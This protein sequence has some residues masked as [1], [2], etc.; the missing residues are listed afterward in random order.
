MTNK[1]LICH[2]ENLAPGDKI[3]YQHFYLGDDGNMTVAVCQYKENPNSLCIGTSFCS[4]KDN[5]S[6]KTGRL[7]ALRHLVSKKRLTAFLSEENFKTYT[8]FEIC[9]MAALTAQ[10]FT[11]PPWMKRDDVVMARN[12]EDL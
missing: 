7:I 2:L 10:K 12:C 1:E 6:R 9:W 3:W 11:S 5:F 8:P 4:P